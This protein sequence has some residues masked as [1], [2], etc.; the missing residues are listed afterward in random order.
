MLTAIEIHDE[1]K[2]IMSC[3]PFVSLLCEQITKEDISITMQLSEDPGTRFK[4][5][6]ENISKIYFYRKYRCS[7]FI[8][9]KTRFIKL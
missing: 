1:C 6:I 5:F 2:K 7:F 8:K 4:L 3:T 9:F